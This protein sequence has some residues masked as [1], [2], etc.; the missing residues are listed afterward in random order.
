MRDQIIA[1]VRTTMQGVVTV[2]AASVSAW[3]LTKFGIDVDLTTV[4][5]LVVVI[6][7]GVVTFVLN[8]L[9]ERFPVIGKILSL[10][11]SA[12]GPSY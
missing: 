7:L 11:M 2:A 8:W 9:Q 1:A 10:G 5:P 12:S 3:L 4:V 6:A